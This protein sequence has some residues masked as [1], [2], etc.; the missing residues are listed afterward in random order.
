MPKVGLWNKDVPPTLEARLVIKK[1]E[2]LLGVKFWAIHYVRV[3]PKYEVFKYVG[4]S[5]TSGLH[6]FESL[7]DKTLMGRAAYQILNNEFFKP[8][9]FNNAQIDA[10]IAEGKDAFANL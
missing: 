5:K 9:C 4:F 2:R 7:K 8:F 3:V 6:Y 1:S 10:A